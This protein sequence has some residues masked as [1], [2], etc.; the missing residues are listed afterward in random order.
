LWL[1]APPLADEP[2]TNQRGTVTKVQKQAVNCIQYIHQT[3]DTLHFFVLILT[4]ITI[5]VA[6]FKLDQ[7]KQ[8]VKVNQVLVG[9]VGD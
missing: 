7:M 4:L 6:K 2:P 8:K 1:H 5:V 3:A 9:L